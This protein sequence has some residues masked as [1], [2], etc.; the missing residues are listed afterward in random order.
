M[1]TPQE[2]A[3]DAALMSH[4]AAL[5]VIGLPDS[6]APINRRGQPM[7]DELDAFRNERVTVPVTLADALHSLTLALELYETAREDE[8]IH[9]DAYN[10]HNDGTEQRREQA[11]A[12][13]MVADPKATPNPSEEQVATW[14]AALGAG[15]TAS[16]RTAAEK[17]ADVTPH[18]VTFLARSREL[19]RAKADAEKETSVARRRHDTLKLIVTAYTT[20]GAFVA[21]EPMRLTPGAQ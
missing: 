13:L 20:V 17:L 11:I 10:A 15:R 5:D 18:M 16:S 1:D 21:T 12:A 9:A 19:W 3:G 8:R 14:T 7:R 2:Q 4:T 6:W